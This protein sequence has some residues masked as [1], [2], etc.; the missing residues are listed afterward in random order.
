[1]NEQSEDPTTKKLI[2][3]SPPADLHTP[4]HHLRI[5]HHAL[6]EIETLL[7]AT[8]EIDKDSLEVLMPLRFTV[9]ILRAEEH[10]KLFKSKTLYI[11]FVSTG[12]S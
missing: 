1:M 9:H 4:H 12:S 5:A 2:S 11:A 8:N 10:A 3:M 7:H 6:E